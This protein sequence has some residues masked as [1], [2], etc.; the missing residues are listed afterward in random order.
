VIRDPDGWV[1][2]VVPAKSGLEY[3]VRAPT[4]AGMLALK[5]RVIAWCVLALCR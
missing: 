1:C 2:N 4:M 5:K 3:G